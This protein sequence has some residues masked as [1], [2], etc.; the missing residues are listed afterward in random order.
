MC[1]GCST[2][3]D[4]S[5]FI[6]SLNSGALHKLKVQLIKFFNIVSFVNIPKKAYDKISMVE[7]FFIHTNLK[8][9][10]WQK[11]SILK[12]SFRVDIKQ[13]R[14]AKGLKWK[15]MTGVDPILCQ[16]KMVIVCNVS[17]ASSWA[18]K[19]TIHGNSWI[20]V[21]VLSRFEI[22]RYLNQ[23][24]YTNLVPDFQNPL[25]IHST[26]TQIKKEPNIWF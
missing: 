11:R 14:W 7:T 15:R 10:N 20:F 23:F 6:D 25:W 13:E 12:L 16:M 19:W 4:D 3:I 2:S 1:L 26:C 17:G 24:V 8:M 18:V 21:S 9:F 5:V 22:L